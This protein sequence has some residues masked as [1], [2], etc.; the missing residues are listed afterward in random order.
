MEFMNGLLTYIEQGSFDDLD[1]AN[2]RGDIP[3][4]M[5]LTV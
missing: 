3:K 1:F 4:S 2:P 5:V